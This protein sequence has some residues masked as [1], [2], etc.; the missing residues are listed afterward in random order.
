MLEKLGKGALFGLGI[1][2]AV[3]DGLGSLIGAGAGYAVDKFNNQ[4]VDNQFD[5]YSCFLGMMIGMAKIDGKFDDEEKE[6]ILKRIKDC[7]YQEK[8]LYHFLCEAYENIIN[9]EN[10]NIITLARQYDSFIEYDVED[11]EFI[12]EILFEIACIDN[13]LSENEIEILQKLPK[14]LGLKQEI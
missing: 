1:G 12:Y 2:Y 5:S 13:E 11:R 4:N 10:I 14:Y 7:Y 3:A 9:E 6:L 8:E